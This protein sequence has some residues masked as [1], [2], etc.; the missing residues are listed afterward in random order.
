MKVFHPRLSRALAPLALLGLLGAALLPAP[1]ARAEGAQ[2]KPT[3]EVLAA[4]CVEQ[5]NAL[6]TAARFRIRETAE[7][8]ILRIHRLDENGA[9][10]PA[11]LRAAGKGVRAVDAVALGTRER[12]NRHA[13]RCLRALAE[14]G[15]DPLLVDQVNDARHGAL[16]AVGG[17]AMNARHAILAAADEATGDAASPGA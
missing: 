1:L 12:I 15:A 10:D 8:T 17:A 11:I 3:G 7:S 5:I 14:I 6:S 4:E 9:P 13:N 16:E 2:G